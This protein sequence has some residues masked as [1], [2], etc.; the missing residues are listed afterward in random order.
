MDDN[1]GL[2]ISFDQ[3]N[4][5]SKLCCFE[6]NKLGHVRSKCPKLKKNSHF[7]NEEGDDSTCLSTP[8]GWAS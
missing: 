8:R 2:E 7:Q 1:T 6:C 3:L 5:M 4:R